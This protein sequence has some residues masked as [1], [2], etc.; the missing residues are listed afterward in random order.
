METCQINTETCQ[1]KRKNY[2]K[3]KKNCGWNPSK[4]ICENDTFKKY[5]CWIINYV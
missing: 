2:H 3:C 5:C 4:C 1:C